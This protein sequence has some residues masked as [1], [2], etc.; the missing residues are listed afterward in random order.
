MKSSVSQPPA[1]L[2]FDFSQHLVGV[3]DS[4][5][6]GHYVELQ[7]R[8]RFPQIRLLTLSDQENIPYGDKTPAQILTCVTPFIR[9][10][11][12]AQ[13]EA[14]VIA[15]NTCYLNLAD[16]L[17]QLATGPLLGYEPALEVAIAQ[18]KTRSVA[19]CA[20]P[21]A[22]AS[23]RWQALKAQVADQITIT[24]IDCR[25]WVALMESS[26]LTLDHLRPAIEQL[27]AAQADSLLLGCTHYNWLRT[28]LQ[29][30]LP[31]GYQLTVYESTPT[32]LAD[33]AKVLTG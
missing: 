3:F 1:P 13:V 21:S 14:I 30:L 8:Q 9:Q 27:V 25:P 17:R 31:S 29:S 19:V 22:L 5:L 26:K 28:S 33:L 18:T 6:G 2:N 15:C 20:T 7:I 16:E 12:Q 32:V 10:F 11:N 4:G 23:R 24:E